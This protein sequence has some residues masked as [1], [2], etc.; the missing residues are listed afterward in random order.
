MKKRVSLKM[1]KKLHTA[2][3]GCFGICKFKE[4]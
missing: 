3:G 1:D 4:T 2:M